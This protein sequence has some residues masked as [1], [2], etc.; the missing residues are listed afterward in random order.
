[1]NNPTAASKPLS[2]V[3]GIPL[4]EE[5]AVGALTLGGYLDELAGR[6]GPREA[7]NMRTADGSVVRWTY[8]ELHA[9]SVDVA[10]ALL[11]C[12]VGKGTRVGILMTNRLEYL[13]AFFGIAMAGGVATTMSTFSTAAE[14][15]VLVAK[16]GCSVLL[17]ERNVL[18]K[19]FAAML[20][21]MEPQVGSSAPG[22][23]HSLKFPFLRYIAAV[24]EAPAQGAVEGWAPFLARG[25]GI[26]PALVAATAATVTPAD[27]GVLYFSS[28]STGVPKGILSAHRGVCLQLWRWHTWLGAS[29]DVR[30]WPAN[31]F[32]WAG[33]FAWVVG[34]SLSGG[35]TLV[36]QPTF[37]AE[38]ALALMEEEKVNFIAAWPHQWAQLM[39]AKNWLEVDLSA[40]KY[41]DKF[42]PL[43]GHPSIDSDWIE[44]AAAYGNTETFTLVTVYPANT[45]KEIS[46]GTHGV[47]TAGTTIRIVDPLSGEITPLGEP[48]EITVKGPTLMLGY[49][50]IPLDES[51]DDDGYLHTGDG[52]FI[53]EQGRLIWEGRLNDIIKTG[54]ANVS[55]VEIDIV[56]AKCP[57][58]KV[59]KTVGVP[60]E[61]LGER[62]VACI[63]PQDGVELSAETVRAFA[64]QQL[65]SYKVPREVLFFAESE[66]ELTGSAK[67][68]SSE[69]RDLATRRLSAQQG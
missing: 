26:D 32:F 38:E 48:G 18:K 13:S 11:A 55:P 46:T 47:P 10:R 15:E 36:M 68:K 42:S 60:D 59:T 45:P 40:M 12:G 49:L 37:Q 14:L 43:A 24:D 17:L 65:A 8:D 41:I 67:V 69:L 34:G 21:E 20:T 7:A 16:S 51:L 30:G 4:E 6:F 31:G 66:L 22:A 61:L 9:R 63:V 23:I 5:A 35:G 58:V 2:L 62:V 64:K 25:E 19:D 56:I 1:M 52:G 39:D 28:G 44:P 27:P 54:G 50:G 57:G 53:D 29:D 3:K 33:N